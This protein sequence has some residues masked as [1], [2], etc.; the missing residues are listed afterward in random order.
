MPP[1]AGYWVLRRRQGPGDPPVHAA[2]AS[3]YAHVTAPLRRLVDRFANEI[4]L[5]QCAGIAPP[6]WVLEALEAI[7]GV[8][9]ESGAR[10]RRAERAAVDHVEC[11]LLGGRIGERFAGVVVDVRDGRATVQIADPAVVAPLEDEGATPGEAITTVLREVDQVARR[12]R[13]ARA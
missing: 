4:V 9:A 6:G 8:M 10:E 12:V 3:V 2:I 11:A 13:F 5:A 7:P 1:V